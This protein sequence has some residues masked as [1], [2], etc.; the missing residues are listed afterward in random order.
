M[1]FFWPGAAGS[2]PAGQHHISD[3]FLFYIK[4]GDFVVIIHRG[5]AFRI[6]SK[7][8]STELPDGTTE[9]KTEWTISTSYETNNVGFAETLQE[10]EEVLEEMVKE[11]K[12]K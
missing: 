7:V 8:R 9:Q 12:F 1:D 3:V 5:Y 6:T 2:T 10:V 4:G 11:I